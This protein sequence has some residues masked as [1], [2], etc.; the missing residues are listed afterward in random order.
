[1]SSL[2][3]IMRSTLTRF[4]LMSV[5]VVLAACSG[6]SRPKPTEIQ[7]VPVLQD[8]RTRW[9]ANVGKVDFPLVVSAR[10]DRIALAPSWTLRQAKMCGV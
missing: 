5:C 8:V 9:T 7:G 6:T 1:M 3:P 10:D 4:A 2:T